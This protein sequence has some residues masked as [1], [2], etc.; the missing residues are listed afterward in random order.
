MSKEI[1]RVL[2]CIWCGKKLKGVTMKKVTIPGTRKKQLVPSRSFCVP[3]NNF[4]EPLKKERS[5]HRRFKYFYNRLMG[6]NSPRAMQQKNVKQFI[7]FALSQLIERRPA[8]ILNEQLIRLCK[9]PAIQ[10]MMESN[11]RKFYHSVE[12]SNP[13]EII[14]EY[15]RK[16]Q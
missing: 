10:R 2:H 16:K 13:Q 15:R 11:F 6:N 9:Q 1:K 8:M 14:L 5:C 4:A 3:E 7:Q 12:E